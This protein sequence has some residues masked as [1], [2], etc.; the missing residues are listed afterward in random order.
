MGFNGSNVVNGIKVFTSVASALDTGNS[1][2][3]LVNT[4]NTATSS[5]PMLCPS[6]SY[7]TGQPPTC[8]FCPAGTYQDSLNSSFC[9]ACPAGA[10]CLEGCT[11]SKGSGPCSQGTYSSVGTGTNSTCSPC[12]ANRYC[13]ESFYPKFAAFYW[14]NSSVVY[15]PSATNA[16]LPS[17]SSSPLSL[18]FARGNRVNLGIV[19]LKPGLTGFSTTVAAKFTGSPQPWERLFEFGRGEWSLNLILVR[20][21]DSSTIRFDSY[22]TDQ[23]SYEDIAWSETSINPLHFH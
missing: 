7:W 21:W 9:L 10:Y 19:T 6:G 20:V 22:Q 18:T 11:S 4:S 15:Y 23:E 8:A 1:S 13:S 3:P 12:P 2:D 14:L 17:V 16:N 5:G